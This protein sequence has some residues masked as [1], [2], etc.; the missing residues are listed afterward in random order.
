MATSL[1]HVVRFNY[2]NSMPL[3]SMPP[4]SS[5][6]T[7]QTHIFRTCFHDLHRAIQR[8]TRTIIVN[9]LSTYAA[10]LSTLTLLVSAQA[11]DPLAALPSNVTPEQVNS[12]YPPPNP[13]TDHPPVLQ[14]R[15]RYR[16]LRH[17]RRSPTAI[18]QRRLRP[19]ERGPLLPN[20]RPRS[21][22]HRLL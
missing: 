12:P 5:T 1:G 20:V 15:Q 10:I 2:L 11:A 6:H 14:S 22:S 4:C 7:I 3:L 9:M 18:H 21:R 19:R 8:I 17:L 13:Q 16:R